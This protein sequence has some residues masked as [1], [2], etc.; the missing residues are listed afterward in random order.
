MCMY[1]GPISLK[2]FFQL[3]KT[4]ILMEP[5]GSLPSSEKY[6]QLEPILSQFNPVYILTLHFSKNNIIIPLQTQLS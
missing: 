6:T 3:I 1:D 4:F 5:E 2:V